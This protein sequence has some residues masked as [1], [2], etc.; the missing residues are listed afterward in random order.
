MHSVTLPAADSQLTA[1]I[2]A[3]EFVAAD[4]NPLGNYGRK[5]ITFAAEEMSACNS[6]MSG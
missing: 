4:G 3:A 2:A 5:T 6:D 1:G